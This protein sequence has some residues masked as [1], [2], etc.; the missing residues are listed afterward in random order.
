MLETV[1][2]FRL[3]YNEQAKGTL[4]SLVATPSLL[5]RVMKSQWQDVEIVSIRDRVQSG[6]GDEGWIVHTDGGLRYREQVVV[7]H[8]TE[9]REEILMEFHCSRFSVHPG[10]SKMYQDLRRQY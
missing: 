3:Q 2:Q 4:G 9:L 8:S 5:S 7:P 1:G 6:M 10:G